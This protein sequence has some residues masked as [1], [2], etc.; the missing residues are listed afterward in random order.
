MFSVCGLLKL[1]SSLLSPGCW[2]WWD[3]I[4]SDCHGS[5]MF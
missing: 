5:A 2:Y 4:Y 3:C 1:M